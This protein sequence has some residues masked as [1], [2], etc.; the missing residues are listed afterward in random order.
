MRTGGS[1]FSFDPAE[2]GKTAATAA[3]AGVGAAATAP[4]VVAHMPIL[5]ITG[6]TAHGFFLLRFIVSPNTA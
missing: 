3:Y 5:K 4:T 6:K 1:G 2:D